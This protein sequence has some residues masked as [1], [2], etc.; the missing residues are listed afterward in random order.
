MKAV[1]NVNF[2]MDGEI[3]DCLISKGILIYSRIFKECGY[4]CIF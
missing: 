1:G 2:F 3:L 4:I